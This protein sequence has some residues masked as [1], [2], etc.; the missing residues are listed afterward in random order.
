MDAHASDTE[1]T[2]KGN[3]LL[4]VLAWIVVVPV[5]Y[6]IAFL[7]AMMIVGVNK[8]EFGPPLNPGGTLVQLAAWGLM[9]WLFAR[10]RRKQSER[11]NTG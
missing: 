1:G 6:V 10:M 5:T 3:R 4:G 9:L 2:R 11:R 7:I 8:S